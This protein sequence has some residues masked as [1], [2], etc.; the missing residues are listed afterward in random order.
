MK[1]ECQLVGSQKNRTL[2][3][4]PN[5]AQYQLGCILFPLILDKIKKVGSLKMATKNPNG[6]ILTSRKPDFSNCSTSDFLS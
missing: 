1:C 5:I 2:S 3:R 4:N 6:T